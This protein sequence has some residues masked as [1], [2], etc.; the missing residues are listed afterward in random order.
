LT[1]HALYTSNLKHLRQK[2]ADR[3]KRLRT[4]A[5]KKTK[6]TS[7]KVDDKNRFFYL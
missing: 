7:I 3:N 1:A 2:G 4:I 5:L 6:T